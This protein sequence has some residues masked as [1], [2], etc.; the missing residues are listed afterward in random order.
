VI[1]G[2]NDELILGYGQSNGRAWRSDARAGCRGPYSAHGSISDFR[3]EKADGLFQAAS[4]DAEIFVKAVHAVDSIGA[5]Y[6]PI[7][8]LLL[9]ITGAGK[10]SIDAL[11]GIAAP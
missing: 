8:M 1:N 6:C 3:L 2:I 7:T 4:H 9:S 10:Y 5:R 11:C